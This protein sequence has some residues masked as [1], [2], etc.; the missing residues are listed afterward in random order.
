MLGVGAGLER[1][2]IDVGEIGG[3]HADK[4]YRVVMSD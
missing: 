4:E 1:G 3:W 2:Q